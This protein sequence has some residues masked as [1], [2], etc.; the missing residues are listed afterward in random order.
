MKHPFIIKAGLFLLSCFLSP[1]MYGQG[2][3]HRDGQKIVDGSGKEVILRGM[4]LGGYMLQE[5]YMFETADFARTQ[6]EI[7]SKIKDLVGS[8]KTDLFYNTY[9]N[10]YITRR[11][12]D[13]MA[14]WGFNS[15]RLPLHYN[16]FITEG[17][18]NQFVEKGFAMVDTLLKWCE[19][20]HIYLILD[21][22]ATPGGQG[23]DVAISDRDASKPS[24]WDSPQNQDKTVILWKELARRYSDK[25][26][27][28]G[29]D[30]INETNWDAMKV[31]QNKPLHDI[32]V[33]ITQAIR[34]VDK[35]HILFIEGNS[36]AND[37]TGLTPPWDDNMVYSFHKYWNVN[38]QA[39]IQ[40]MLD[41]RKQYNVP[42]WLGESGE[43]S[44]N[45]F[46]DCIELV[47]NNQI[48]WAFWPMK[49]INSNVGIITVVKNPGYQELL[50][51]WSGK[52]PR[53]DETT[54]FNALMQLTDNYRIE[55]CNIHRDVLYS[56]FDQI[57]NKKT[58]P[59]APNVIPGIVYASNYDLGRNGYAYN[60]NTVQ[61]TDMKS[62]DWN[63]G[64]A[65]RNDGVDIEKCTDLQ[66]S[67]GYNVT[68][69]ES[70]EWIN[71]TVIASKTGT[72]RLS[73]RIAGEKQGSVTIKNNTKVFSDKQLPA[74]K[75]DKDWQ[76]FEVGTLQLQKGKN[77]IQLNFTKGN[78]KL[79]YLKFDN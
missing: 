65:Y 51:Y 5:G 71:Y 27:I 77:T 20:R 44:N 47:E 62:W 14:A 45:W 31:S 56:M 18:Q 35:N 24:L 41:L 61:N 4:G 33:R 26:W 52:S 75:S 42:I 12:V 50:D 76:T 69:I 58:K 43:N 67:N 49:K 53:P 19:V 78:F 6:H 7:R 8:A 28:G 66:P 57:N 16:L 37:F 63:S 34:E 10:N 1:L 32:F 46:T 60:D 48:G 23:N 29:Y 40:W 54:A 3:L 25:Q 72:Y 36:F 15:L 38:N 68:D 11:D 59:F 79:G 70:G 73:F 13:S 21:L 39:S 2:F 30:L 17:E 22:H 55:K 74:T 64:N 9:Q